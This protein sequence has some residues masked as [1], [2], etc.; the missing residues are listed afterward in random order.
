MVDDITR[1]YLQIRSPAESFDCSPDYSNK[2]GNGV[3]TYE[4]KYD[5]AS[6]C[7][8][9]CHARLVCREGYDRHSKRCRDRCKGDQGLKFGLDISP[10]I[11]FPINKLESVPILVGN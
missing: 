11:F 6:G 7:N 9:E 3:R 5:D 8:S 1:T 2:L 10:A 4:N